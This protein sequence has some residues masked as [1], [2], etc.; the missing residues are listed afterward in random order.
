MQVFWEKWGNE[1][2][3]PFY[4]DA[5]VHSC[6][7]SDFPKFYVAIDNEPI[8]GTYALLRND[9]NNRQDLCPWLA[10]LYVDEKYRGKEIGS[11]LLQH[12]LMEAAKKG[13]KKLFLAT[14]LEGYYEKYGWK[15]SGLVYGASGYSINFYEKE[16]N[17]M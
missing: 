5:I 16:T 12:G 6:S 3:Y 7:S 17:V 15:H 2:N 1:D 11:K 14:D 13:Y 10:C 9:L 8:I 4:E